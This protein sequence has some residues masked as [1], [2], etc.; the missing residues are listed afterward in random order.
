MSLYLGIYYIVKQKKTPKIPHVGN[1]ERRMSFLCL[2]T[3]LCQLKHHMNL[4][5][6]YSYLA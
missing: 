2:I 3:K 4:C 6:G 1:V 5:I